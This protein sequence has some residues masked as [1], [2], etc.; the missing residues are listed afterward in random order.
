MEE[1]YWKQFMASGKV[2]DYLY[3][4]GFSVLSRVMERYGST[5]LEEKV[6]ESGEGYG[7]GDFG[8]P[9]RRV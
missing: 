5:P 6:I 9:D 7:D 3:Y 2:A 4:R 1:K 8:R